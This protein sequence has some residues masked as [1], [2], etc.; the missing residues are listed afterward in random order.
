MHQLKN[1][2]DIIIYYNLHFDVIKV[3]LLLFYRTFLTHTTPQLYTLT[4]NIIYPSISLE[5]TFKVIFRLD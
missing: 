5:G 4:G 3:A 2:R 1:S